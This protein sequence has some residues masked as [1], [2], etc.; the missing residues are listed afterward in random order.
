MSER[1][2]K[3]AIV[4]AGMSGCLAA[5]FLARR[6][7]EVEIYELRGDIRQG[8]VGPS[9]SLNM[10]LSLRGLAV[11]AAADSLDWVLPLT[12][13]V[14][15]RMVHAEDGRVRF[16][17]YGDRQEQVLH[18]IVRND[19]NAALM[20]R[21][22]SFP[23]AKIHFRESFLRL[24][25][26]SGTVVFRDLDTQRSHTVE[27]D[28]VVGADG[29]FSAVRRA[30]QRG[31]RADYQ[32]KYLTWDYKELRI[33]PGPNGY[34]FEPHALHVWPRGGCMLMALPNPDG[35]FN[36]IC[37]M[38]AE[39]D[40]GFSSLRTEEQVRA[41][42][43]AKFP[44]AA[45]EMPTLTRDFL[46]NPASAFL[47]VATSPWHYQGK[48]VL[49]GDACHTVVP[50]YGQGMIAGFED[51]ATLDACLARCG[52]DT[53]AAFAEYERLRKRNTDALAALS[54]HNFV[55]LRDRVR[56]LRV[57][58]RK[59]ME[60]VLGR[61]FRRAWIPIYTL[62]AHS[63]VPYADALARYR[64]QRRVARWLGFDLVVGAWAG[65]LALRRLASRLRLGRR[66]APGAASQAAA[67]LPA[68]KGRAQ[69]AA[70][71]PPGAGA[72]P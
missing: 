64:R 25:K 19:L 43:Q 34:R 24:D 67:T 27:A 39:G 21:V 57:I 61:V 42:F 36:C 60:A 35:S 10:T 23:G 1:P 66:P 46:R 71:S 58:A 50:F 8:F 5:I 14:R 54:I 69:A 48:V 20:N 16:Q 7:Y 15:G 44:D 65:L 6:G 56:D 26:E 40:P 4:G 17:P 28:F 3:V 72:L 45:A 62:I 55:E 52:A 32:Q 2:R 53:A 70:A 9:R 22:E 49:V 33:P 13:P 11:L 12:V 37:T 38:P 29:C 47:S 59:Q 68:R 41:F 18:A 51:C 31:E 30:A 63:S